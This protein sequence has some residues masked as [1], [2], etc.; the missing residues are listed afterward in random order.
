M[1]SLTELVDD[2]AADPGRSQVEGT[3]EI[4]RSQLRPLL[5]D[6]HA[7]GS[8]TGPNRALLAG[9][10][11][12]GILGQLYPERLGGTST[13]EGVGATVLCQLREGLA[14][15]ATE[16]ESALALQGLGSYPI[17]Q[18]AQPHVAQR[19]I[20]EIAAGRAI[21][22]FA[23]SEPASGTDAA[24]LQ[25]MAEEDG[26]GFRLT[27]T[28]KWISNAPDADVYTLFART[29]G[30]GSRGVTAFVVPGDSPGLSG[31]PLQMLAPHP[32]GRLDL[33]D[34]FVPRDHVLGEVNRGFVVAM[35]T[36]DLFRPSVAACSVGM[37]QSALELAIEYANTRRAFGQ[38]LREFQAVAH[39]LADMATKIHAARLMV[40]HAAAAYESGSAKVTQ[41][42]AMTKLFATEMA[43]EVVDA[44]Q[45]IHGAIGLEVGHPL[46]ALYREVR[47]PRIYEGTS[48]IQRTI[49]SRE[50]YR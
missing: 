37:A 47:S 24:A 8:P 35:R 6:R 21:A 46:E 5:H 4:A 18:S 32:V 14:S 17:V 40:Y 15:E 49:I 23:L 26:D 36:L 13:Q 34:V 12:T 38:P 3:R 27:G 25:C 28:K 19:W 42:A 50:M 9:L 48:E 44:S 1:T 7:P 20:P 2:S 22:A 33:D 39:S 43:Q 30:G 11:S 16:A 41:L 31:E 10:A 45:Q 29:G